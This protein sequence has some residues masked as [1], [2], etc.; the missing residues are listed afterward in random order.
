VTAVNGRGGI[1]L[2]GTIF[3]SVSGLFCASTA[4][5]VIPAQAGISWDGARPSAFAGDDGSSDMNPVEGNT[6]QA[7]R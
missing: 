1:V 7:T 4:A 3:Q 6:R 5:A 2:D